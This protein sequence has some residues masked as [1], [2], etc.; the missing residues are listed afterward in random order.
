MIEMF[1]FPETEFYSLA[2]LDGWYTGIK[3]KGLAD[4]ERDV[5]YEDNESLIFSDKKWTAYDIDAGLEI[6][7]ERDFDRLYE[8]VGEMQDSIKKK[9]KKQKH[10]KN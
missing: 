5:I 4:F 1:S 7:K 10:I 6:C 3:R 9:E 8:K 2:I